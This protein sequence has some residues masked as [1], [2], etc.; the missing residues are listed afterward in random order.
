MCCL[1]RI[2]LQHLSFLNQMQKVNQEVIQRYEQLGQNFIYQLHQVPI[3]HQ[4]NFPYLALLLQIELT[5]LSWLNSTMAQTSIQYPYILTHYLN[6][7]QV[8]QKYQSHWQS[9]IYLSCNHSH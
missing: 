2:M 7:K 4:S 6:H 9:L 8:S 3:I 5:L 1:H